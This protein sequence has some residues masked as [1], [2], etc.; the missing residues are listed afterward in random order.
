MNTAKKAIVMQV[1]LKN[2]IMCY[3]ILY[4]VVMFVFVKINCKFFTV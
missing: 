4:V 2:K 1:K 3:S